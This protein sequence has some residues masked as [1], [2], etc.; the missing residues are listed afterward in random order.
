M[1]PLPAARSGYST[2]SLPRLRGWLR[3]ARSQVLPGRQ[4]D[5]HLISAG[6]PGIFAT[7]ALELWSVQ[8]LAAPLVLVSDGPVVP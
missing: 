2:H 4:L 6:M 8:V 5:W 7:T 1:E 3:V